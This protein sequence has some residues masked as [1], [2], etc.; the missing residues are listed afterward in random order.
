MEP[1]DNGIPASYADYLYRRAVENNIKDYAIFLTD[2]AGRV[3]NWNRG[4]ERILGYTEN[5]IIGQSSFIFFTPEDRLAHVPEGEIDTATA[6]GRAE[7][8]R[9]LYVKTKRGSG[10]PA[11][12]VR[13]AMKTERWLG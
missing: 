11:L 4:A 2:T 3:I 13:C 5:E 9:G 7:D 12:S 6:T 10:P 1:H 8:E